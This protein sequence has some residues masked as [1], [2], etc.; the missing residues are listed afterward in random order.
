MFLLL[1]LVVAALLTEVVEAILL[2]QL[3]RFLFC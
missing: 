1:E 3:H 2:L